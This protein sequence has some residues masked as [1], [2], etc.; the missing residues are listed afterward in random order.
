MVS[1]FL[2]IMIPSHIH[3]HTNVHIFKRLYLWGGWLAQS[4]EHATLGLGVL[5]SSPMLGVAI[6]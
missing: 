1:K 3:L 5:S 2:T 6:T 4:G